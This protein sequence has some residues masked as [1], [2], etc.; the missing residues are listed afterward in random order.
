MAS[1]E[2]SKIL[3]FKTVT[4]ADVGWARGY[5]R[6]R[7]GR[8]PMANNLVSYAFHLLIFQFAA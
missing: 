6:V 5:Y 7:I 1:K 4:K 3:F 2:K 8:L